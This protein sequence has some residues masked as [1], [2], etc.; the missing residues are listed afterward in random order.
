MFNN[1]IAV[2]NRTSDAVYQLLVNPF[3]G[4]VLVEF[5]NG[6]SYQ[7]SN[8]S[9]RAIANLLLNK[10]MSLGFWVN[11]NCINAARTSTL[12]LQLG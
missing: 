2:T 6:Y 11:E 12:A 8:V 9:R 10:N 7:Y 1:F 5:R 4:T 3:Y